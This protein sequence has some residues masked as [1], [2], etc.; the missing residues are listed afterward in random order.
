MVFTVAGWIAIRNLTYVNTFTESFSST[1]SVTLVLFSVLFPVCLGLILY[2]YLIRKNQP[3]VVM[4]RFGTLVDG[5]NG[6]EDKRYE[7]VIIT[8]L[9]P[10]GRQLICA[11]A[12]T[13][14]NEWQTT[15]FFF[16]MTTLLLFGYML[17]YKRFVLGNWLER[18]DLSI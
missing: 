12:V 5:V 3:A 17:G 14:M 9:I 8:V 11:I 15:P 2:Y 18:F 4:R 7:M 1:L 16:I 13:K 10:L 6:I